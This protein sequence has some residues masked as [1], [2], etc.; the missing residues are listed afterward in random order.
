MLMEELPDQDVK[1]VIAEWVLTNGRLPGFETRVKNTLPKWSIV[2]PDG[3][4]V[5]RAQ[6]R[7]RSAGD[8]SLLVDGYRPVIATSKTSSAVIRYAAPSCC[9]F[10]IHLA[11]GVRYLDVSRSVIF[12]TQEGPALAIKNDILSSICSSLS[13]EVKWPTPDTQPSEAREA[14]LK[15]CTGRMIK[16]I[17]GK[18]IDYYPA[19]QEIMVCGIGGSFTGQTKIAPIHGV[20]AYQV[21]YSVK[22]SGGRRGRTLRNKTK[23]MNKNGRRPT[24]QSK[25]VRNR[26]LGHR[27]HSYAEL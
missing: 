25:N 7:I 10:E 18:I 21:N 26:G 9:L 1:R 6:G 8:P 4:V 19:E 24:R 17:D 5:Y 15:R 3:M 13:G 22:P 23:R 11:P 20:D 2:G 14:M 27:G 16:D 12:S